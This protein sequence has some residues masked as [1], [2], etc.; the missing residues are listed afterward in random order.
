MSEPEF[1]ERNR[2]VTA[3]AWIA[4]VIV[5][6]IVVAFGLLLLSVL[7]YFLVAFGAAIL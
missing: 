5:C 2:A 4:T 6:F 3:F 7:I 1:F